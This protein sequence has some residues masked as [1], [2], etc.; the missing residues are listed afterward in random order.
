MAT[1][2]PKCDGAPRNTGIPAT[3]DHLSITSAPS[4]DRL[5]LT[6]TVT[7]ELEDA[8]ALALVG[9]VIAALGRGRGEGAP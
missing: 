3:L 9:K 4:G 1:K 7:I 8:D 5:A 2:Q 6:G